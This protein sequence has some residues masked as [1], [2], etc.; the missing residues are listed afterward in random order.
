MS[1]LNSKQDVEEVLKQI[2]CD[3]ERYQGCPITSKEH[4]IFMKLMNKVE[5][6]EDLKDFASDII[7]LRDN[8]YNIS[9]Y[10]CEDL[11]FDFFTVLERWSKKIEHYKWEG[12]RND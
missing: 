10:H 9:P 5:E 1:D 6:I 12:D 4:K 7:S 11:E 2:Y 3:V 8:Y